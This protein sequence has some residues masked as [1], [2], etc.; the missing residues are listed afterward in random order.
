M[1]A[2]DIALVAAEAVAILVVVLIFLAKDSL[3]RERDD[4]INQSADLGVRL[5]RLVR[6]LRADARWLDAQARDE[7]QRGNDAAAAA[8]R[9]AA[10][11][12]R[13]RIRDARK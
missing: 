4:A 1:N 7:K 9:S 6:S 5:D 10:S 11:S 12:L 13:Q 3:E 8:F 2:Q